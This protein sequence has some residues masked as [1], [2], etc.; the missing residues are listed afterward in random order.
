MR[1]YSGQVET[2]RRLRHGGDGYW[3]A[4]HWYALRQFFR[5]LRR[6]RP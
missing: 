3:L 2:L 1:A 4:A 5:A 6:P